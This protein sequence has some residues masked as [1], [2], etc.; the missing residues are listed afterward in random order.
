MKKYRV[1]ET[2]VIYNKRRWRNMKKYWVYETSVINNSG[3]HPQG[4]IIC[5]VGDSAL[6][7]ETETGKQYYAYIADLIPVFSDD[8]KSFA[9]TFSYIKGIREEFSEFF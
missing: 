8:D 3:N 4:T 9:E 2:S 5:V 7:E 1:Y 6:I